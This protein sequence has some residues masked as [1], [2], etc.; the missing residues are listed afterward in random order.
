MPDKW[1]YPWF[2]SWDLAF[3]CV[4]Y[5]LI[6][7]QFAKDQLALLCRVWMM[8]P[9]GQLPAYEWDFG[10][11]NP[12]VQ[13]WAALRIF[14]HEKLRDGTG[15]LDFLRDIFDKLLINFTWWVNRKDE[16]GR[17]IFEGGF[18]GMDNVGAF[19]RS[20]PLPNGGRI[21]QS[22]GT[23]WMAMYCLN[24]Q[25]IAIELARNN[26]AYEEMVLKF[27]EH[28]LYI[29][30][31]M[32]GL[33][34]L[35]CSLW[36][37]DDS[38]YYDVL[39]MPS[40]ERLPM[41][42]RSMVGLVPLLAVELVSENPAEQLPTFAGKLE[43]Y[44]H[45]R[46]DLLDL[47]NRWRTEAKNGKRLLSLARGS[48]IEVILGRM[49]DENEFLSPYGIRSL[50]RYHLAHPFEFDD[51]GAHYSV[52]YAPADSEI[53]AYGG[54]SNWRGPVWMPLNYML[55]T[56]LRRLHDYCGED[57]K[58]ECP[59]GSGRVLDLKQVSEDLAGRLV[60]LFVRGADGR[61]P[62]LGA[63]EKLQ[64]DPHFR[65]YIMFSEY[66]NGD[67][68]SGL[69]ASHQTGWTALVAN[70]IHEFF[71]Q[72]PAEPSKAEARSTADLA[73]VSN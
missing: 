13:A 12:P 7:P 19:D 67:D 56:S 4:T 64:T 73:A 21:S 55:V 28:F 60:G 2:A 45:R 53:S 50:S 17:N 34:D 65:D 71:R 6:D 15:D 38:F 23:A 3:H 41:R 26:P 37:D 70:L 1:E 48:R 11:V 42:L 68:G 9:N 66:F 47:V 16:N 22:D 25:R 36:D 46:T 52:K 57:L 8:H 44:W 35:Q 18:L 29:A 10:D 5:A 39:Y 58:V 43:W 59:T 32:T 20:A 49:L 30:R 24:M 61:R 63:N 14:E 33:G 27:F 62:A 31:E 51:Q 54:N 69:G 72:P 40:G